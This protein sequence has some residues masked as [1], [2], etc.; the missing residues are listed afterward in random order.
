MVPDDPDDPTARYQ[1]RRRRIRFD[2]GKEESRP[3]AQRRARGP[4]GLRRTQESVVRKYVV[5]NARG[6]G[7]MGQRTITYFERGSITER[8]TSSLLCF[9]SAALVMLNK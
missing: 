6:H 9:D 3:E 8:L 4:R 1:R 5:R 7:T 2:R